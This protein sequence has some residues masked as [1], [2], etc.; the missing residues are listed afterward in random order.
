M[1]VSDMIRR[2]SKGFALEATFLKHEIEQLLKVFIGEKERRLIYNTT[3]CPSLT[4]LL[5]I[6]PG[7]VVHPDDAALVKGAPNIRRHFLDLQIAQADPLYVHHLMRF[8]RAMRQRNYLLRSKNL[9]T[10][11]SWE[12]EMAH[13]AAYIVFHRRRAVEDLQETSRRLYQELS[14]EASHL[15][16]AYKT[17]A[18]SGAV[19]NALKEYFLA[20][21][22]KWRRKEMELGMTLTGPHK[23]DL[24][25]TLGAKEVRYFASEGQQRSCVAA[26]RLAE[27]ERLKTLSGEPPLMLLDDVGVSLDQS[28]RARLLRHMSTLDQVFLTSTHQ[29]NR[30][31]FGSYKDISLIEI[32]NHSR[33]T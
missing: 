32:E 11:E 8:N 3:A 18:P 29:I 7:V 26:L 15:S 24:S 30:A 13:A 20:Q 9:V 23:D 2:E 31:E 5:G 4:H 12:H 14:G 27:W 16:L 17:S 19:E 33:A 6:L 25:I 21:F 1:Q 10:I 28:R 22:Q